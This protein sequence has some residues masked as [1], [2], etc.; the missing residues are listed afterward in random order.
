[1]LHLPAGRFRLVLNLASRVGSTQCL[2]T[3][4]SSV[5]WSLKAPRHETLWHCTCLSSRHPLRSIC[6]R[7]GRRRWRRWRRRRCRRIC[8]WKR[9]RCVVLCR[10]R[11][12]DCRGFDCSISVRCRS[13]RRRE[14]G[15]NGKPVGYRPECKYQ[16]NH[17]HHQCDNRY[18]QW[19][20][21]SSI[22]AQSGSGQWKQHECCKP[23]H[24]CCRNRS[25]IRNAC[26]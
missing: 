18:R 9:W 22:R 20:S 14:L 25:F 11:G 3:K 21:H 6:P 19:H 17:R 7:W 5:A 1:M 24:Q 15:R 2:G 23:R 13:R 12:F 8:R 4:R 16:S 10:C 26:F